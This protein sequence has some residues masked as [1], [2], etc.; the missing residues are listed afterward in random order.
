[1]INK[2]I[3]IEQKI[4]AKGFTIEVQ[5]EKGVPAKFN[6]MICIK[7]KDKEILS[8]FPSYAEDG[9]HINFNT[10]AKDI[11]KPELNITSLSIPY[12]AIKQLK[13]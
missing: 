10:P 13:K 3:E 6:P 12:E 1:M 11:L 4:K 7:Y 5:N 9:L 8:V 2:N